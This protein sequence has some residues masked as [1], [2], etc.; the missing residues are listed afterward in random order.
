MQKLNSQDKAKG[1]V[2]SSIIP[3][4]CSKRSDLQRKINNK[5]IHGNLAKTGTK[6]PL[7]E[8]NQPRF[9]DPLALQS[10]TVKFTGSSDT[11]NLAPKISTDILSN[12]VN[13]TDNVKMNPSTHA[14][15]KSKLSQKSGKSASGLMLKLSKSKGI[16]FS[17]PKSKKEEVYRNSST[18]SDNIPELT[19]RASRKGS[20]LNESNLVRRRQL[21]DGMGKKYSIFKNL[22]KHRSMAGAG[23]KGVKSHSDICTLT[24]PAKN[25]ESEAK[26][27]GGKEL[28]MADKGKGD[29]LKKKIKASIFTDHMVTNFEEEVIPEQLCRIASTNECT[30]ASTAELAKERPSTEEHMHLPASPNQLERPCRDRAG[31]EVARAN[32]QMA[33]EVRT[34]VEEQ[35]CQDSSACLSNQEDTEI[36]IL[37]ENSSITSNRKMSSNTDNSIVSTASTISPSSPNEPNVS[38]IEEN[39]KLKLSSMSSIEVAEGTNTDKIEAVILAKELVQVQSPDAQVCCCSRRDYLPRESQFSKMHINSGKQM[40]SNLHI[41]P[42]S[43]SFSHCSTFQAD[44]ESPTAS[45]CTMASSDSAAKLPT[46]HDFSSPSPTQSTSKPVLRLMGKN[47]TVECKEET[48]TQLPSPMSNT[49][50]TLKHSSDHGFSNHQ[51]YLQQQ[52]QHHFMGVPLVFSQASSMATN[53]MP[54]H[55]YGIPMRDFILT[56]DATDHERVQRATNISS[57]TIPAS[58][59]LQHGP[60]YPYFQRHSQLIPMEFDGGFRPSFDNARAV[61][62]SSAPGDSVPLPQSMFRFPSPLISH[63]HPSL[64]YPETMR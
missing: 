36:E 23:K 7:V 41:R 11:L 18:M 54:L 4:V 29:I 10:Q 38:K 21:S 46:I 19:T 3:R 64:F 60:V 34:R 33:D 13:I 35:S 51:P 53:Q 26:Y 15:I 27:E 24:S 45:M 50:P 57:A 58:N 39:L 22:R 30:P 5:D 16:V 47:L 42:I 25:A 8:T 37:Q 56:D 49:T 17:S 52:Q 1:N 6:T 43:P 9:V 59:L 12:T 55:S 14:V 63:L 32:D 48:Q 61:Q 31:D 20:T 28:T 40:V 44:M 62:R 2:L